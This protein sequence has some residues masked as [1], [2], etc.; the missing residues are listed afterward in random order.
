VSPQVHHTSTNF[1]CA[2]QKEDGIQ[3]LRWW[4]QWRKA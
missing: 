4:N 3:W 1:P 2:Y